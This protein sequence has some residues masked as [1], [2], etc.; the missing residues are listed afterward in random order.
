MDG[1]RLGTFLG[2]CGNCR[3][4]LCAGGGKA[5]WARASGFPGDTGDRGQH[6]AGL[7]AV[8]GPEAGLPE[9]R[10]LQ[11]SQPTAGKCSDF[12]LPLCLLSGVIQ[13]P[14]I[15]QTWH[16]TSL[17]R[18]NISKCSFLQ[19]DTVTKQKLCLYSGNVC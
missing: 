13:T 18:G 11:D 19:P 3:D 10:G 8:G 17:T 1:R 4:W 5:G 9:Q 12:H 7:G 15:T 14:P 16:L 2:L 6:L